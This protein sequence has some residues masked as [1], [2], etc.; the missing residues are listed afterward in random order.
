M[1]L[2]SI[3][4]LAAHQGDRDVRI[5]DVRWYLKTS[6]LRGRDAYAAGHLPGAVFVDLE[7]ELAAP[8][9]GTKGR[10]PLPAAESFVAAMRRHGISSDT[11]VVACDDAGGAVAA[12]LWWLLRAHGHQRVSLLDG[13]LPAWTA[14]G[15]PVESTPFEYPAGNFESH[16]ISGAS[17]TLEETRRGLRSGALLL[18]ARAGERYR[19]DVEPVDPRPGHIPGAVS[20]PFMD[21]LEN[22]RFRDSE[23][24][25]AR[26]HALGLG[27]RPVL[28]SC[29]SG[30]TACHL[31]FAFD[32][33][34]VAPFPAMKLYVGSFSEW[35]RHEALPVVVGDA[36]GACS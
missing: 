36:P 11:H 33:A 3:D 17:V 8:D 16:W 30:V 26:A 14:G 22:G 7:G 28:A 21:L 9:D 24:L 10:H 12:R 5:C 20:Q 13:G 23:A 6:G 1:G 29:G 25:A 31:I 27:G 19:G 4:W 34:G 2:V 18:D 35:S 15:H 32:H